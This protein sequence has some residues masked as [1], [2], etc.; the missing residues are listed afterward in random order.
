MDGFRRA[1]YR[2]KAAEV[3]AVLTSLWDWQIQ[4]KKDIGMCERINK[5]S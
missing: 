2:D 1:I 4:R 3:S 5:V